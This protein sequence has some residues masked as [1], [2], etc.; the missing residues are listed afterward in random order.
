[1][2]IHL[3]PLLLAGPRRQ[4]DRQV[5]R[6]LRTPVRWGLQHGL[7][8]L[9]IRRAAERGDLQARSIIDPAH[10]LDPYPLY[11]Q[12]RDRGALL[13]SR[14]GYVTATHAVAGEVLR[15]ED[16]QASSGDAVFPPAL[17]P[18]ARWSRDPY[19]LG[20]VDPPSLLVTDPPDHTRYRRLVSKVFTARAIA[21]LRDRVQELAEELLASMA[22][23]PQVEL[24]DAYASRLPVTVIC[25]IL[26]VRPA[27]HERVLA[28]G[29]AGAP[30]LDVGLGYAQFRSVD[31]AVRE[32]A[33]W[34]TGHLAHV[35]RE[36]G[37][38]LFSQLVGLEDE[39][40]RLDDREL[41][42]LAGLIL[43]AG[44]ETTV[45]L[46]GNATVLLTEHPEQLDRLRAEPQLWANAVEE[47]LRFESPVQL[48]G[49]LASRTT[50]VAGV[51]V[52]A[53]HFVVTMLGGANRDPAIF[54]QP[55]RFDAGRTNAREHLS[56]SADRHFCLGAALARLEGE[57]G[58]RS[59]FERFP[60]LEIAPGARRTTTRVLRGWE[61]LP[62]RPEG[63]GSDSIAR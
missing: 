4:L 9:A 25:E 59:L 16:F 61:H 10:R 8:R 38:D 36:P 1:M 12:I 47:V 46:L 20:P 62:V 50:E 17:R 52:G 40:Q 18:L 3:P 41:R 43:A 2:S 54:D 14:I 19:A 13:P 31:R 6:H 45:N 15:S 34:L 39:G 56:F 63:Q 30:S 55:D 26:G 60:E 32:F 49:R 7:P 48:T 11:R 42:A 33:D 23:R 35:R 27:D 44:F 22:G 37:D 51:E 5:S 58:L 28:F 21:G 57:I 29:Q 53:G 24:V